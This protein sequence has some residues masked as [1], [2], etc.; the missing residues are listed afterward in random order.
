[1]G[2]TAAIGFLGALRPKVPHLKLLRET[3]TFIDVAVPQKPLEVI[4]TSL[5]VRPQ[6]LRRGGVS[7]CCMCCE[8][9]G[10]RTSVYEG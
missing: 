1:M 5:T 4:S 9:K 3:T 8:G 10:C 2:V 7:R 6:L